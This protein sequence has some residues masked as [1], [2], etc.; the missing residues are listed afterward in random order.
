[1]IKKPASVNTLQKP[2]Q[3]YFAVSIIDNSGV[4][5]APLFTCVFGKK[6]GPH[7]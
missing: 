1:M 6:M 5:N 3:P 4:K 2:R 7:Y